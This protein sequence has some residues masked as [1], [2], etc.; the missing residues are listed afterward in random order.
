[1]EIYIYMWVWIRIKIAVLGYEIFMIFFIFLK[2]FFDI[3]TAL[4]NEYKYNQKINSKGKTK[5]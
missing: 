4:I 3:I 1:M 5:W 2:I